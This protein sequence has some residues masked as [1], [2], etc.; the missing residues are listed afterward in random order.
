MTDSNEDSQNRS[1]DPLSE[2]EPNAEEG[3]QAE[4]S[5][6]RSDGQDQDEQEVLSLLDLMNE[7]HSD[8]GRPPGRESASA[9][10]PDPIVNMPDQFDDATG[11]IE[12][13]IPDEIQRSKPAPSLYESDLKPFD[14][15]PIDD[16]DATRVSPDLAYPGATRLDLPDLTDLNPPA[17]TPPTQSPPNPDEIRTQYH[18]EIPPTQPRRE[19][20]S[21]P[22]RAADRGQTSGPSR[23]GRP[24][25]ESGS[26]S[27]P[28]PSQRPTLRSEPR[29]VTE[30]RRPGT[31]ASGTQGRPPAQ[32]IRRERPATPRPPL[33]R[34]ETRGAVPGRD[35]NFKQ[36]IPKPIQT[37]PVDGFGC[38]RR[39]LIWSSLLLIIGVATFVIA[40]S[41][42]Y[43][44]IAR[45]LPAPSEIAS[46]ASTF[47][48]ARVLDRDGNLLYELA[49]PNAG[50]RTSVSLDQIADVLEEA[51]I[52]TEDA[53]FYFHPGFDPIGIARAILQAYQ[54]GEV[55]SG[56]STITQQLARALLL[57]EEERSQRTLRR[58]V[59]EII[60]AA[61]ITR[62]YQ[63][64]RG[65]ILELYLNE[66]N[67]GNRAYG[68]QAAAETYFQKS[69]ADLTLAE[70][71]LLAGLPQAPAAWDPYTAPD[72]AIGRM[73]EVLTLMVQEGYV[74]TQEAQAAIDEMAVRVYNLPPLEVTINHPHAV[75]YVLSQLEEANDAQSIYRGGLRIYTTIDPNLQRIA[76]ETLANNRGQINGWGADNASLISI[77][78]RT[79]EIL[80]MVGSVDFNDEAI[81]GQV[82]MAIQ[83]RQ[84]G[85][86]IK[87]FVFLAALEDG[88]TPSTLLWDVPTQFPDNPN[89]PYAPKNY[90]DEFHGPLLLREAL[91]NSYN[92]PAVKALE[93]VGVCRFIDY[94][95]GNFQLNSL[96][97]D[98]CDT[99]GDST[100]YG[101]ALALGGGETSP[102]E[103][104][105]AYG[106][107]ANNG[108][109]IQPYS[110]ARIEDKAGNI[111]FER[112]TLPALQTASP[113]ETYQIV[114][115]LSDNN[116]RLTEFGQNNNLVVPGH[117]VGSKTGTSGTDRFDVRDGWTIGFSPEIA[118]AVWVGNTDNRPMAEGASG[119]QV[120]S[121]IWNSFM[122]QALSGRAA[123]P[124]ARP[125]GLVELE[126]CTRSG[127]VPSDSCPERRTEIFTLENPPLDADQD[128]LRQVSIDLWSGLRANE[129][130]QENVHNATFFNLLVNGQPEVK[131]REEEVVRS[132]M[133]TSGWANANGIRPEDFGGSLAPPPSLACDESTPRPVVEITGPAAY[134]EVEEEIELIGSA[135][136]PN[137]IGYRID[138]GLSHNPEGWGELQGLTEN[139]IENGRLSRFNAE[140][141]GQPGPFTVRLVLIGPPNP[142]TPE[143]E[144]VTKSVL[145][146]LYIRQPTPTPTATPTATPTN[147][148]TPT[149]TPTVTHTPSPT[150]TDVPT[151]TATPTDT[152]EPTPTRPEPEPEDTPAVEP[153]PTE[154][155]ETEE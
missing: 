53:R 37:Q 154:E 104:V 118:T 106:M 131:L 1:E 23:P 121:P 87:P 145:H 5:S 91:G 48:T 50:N 49:D 101:L 31:V 112:E 95:R 16:P 127:T 39:V 41:V 7:D 66:I 143:G 36:S 3:G 119:Y 67:Y 29:P 149:A 64:D 152:P 30:P 61:E 94:M 90:D 81:S 38:L 12:Y 144:R 27:T 71:A 70:A 117:N 25:R 125:E 63:D 108:E 56:A 120:A 99:F 110:I 43:F 124:F 13:D 137:A 22:Q 134:A 116:A 33:E 140:N 146:N 73:W 100:N 82:N 47:E 151:E 111:L 18:A 34:V 103:M 45:D 148:A 139:S 59:R 88:W 128:F 93:Y 153:V 6:P 72:K 74:S 42:G 136:H 138:Y 40:A 26:G 147:T 28:T 76:E 62:I 65:A 9:P 20:P 17:S 107:L 14:A 89:P 85:S 51:T 109:V 8:T 10:S 126:I 133:E 113:Q 21:S 102:L 129:F 80:A 115:I 60:L 11:S 35:A 92:I 123:V 24:Q 98:G 77:D 32:P 122:N 68:I 52:A 105:T 97:T 150:V 135:R 79:G 141:I 15:V 2:Q 69:A 55:V 75:F 19:P 57:D 114:D 96:V 132:W 44:F 155:D 4:P 54:E 78:P 84:P 46:R 86:T 130:C 83:P 58:K 142:Y